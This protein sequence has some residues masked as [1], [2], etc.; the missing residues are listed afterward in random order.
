MSDLHKWWVNRPGER[1]WLE[2]TDRTDPGTNLKAPQ[3]N[4][5]GGEFWSYSLVHEVS[6][7]D[8]VFH[9]DRP[10]QRIMG[11]SRATGDIWDDQIVWGART[12][13]SQPTRRAGRERQT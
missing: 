9:Y 3:R 5:T 10:S 1:S 4:E 2:V 8:V 12:K 7:G 13:R 11:V 6:D